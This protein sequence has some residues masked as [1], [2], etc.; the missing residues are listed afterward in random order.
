[1]SETPQDPQPLEQTI[2]RKQYHSPEFRE[3]G[4]L[5]DRTQAGQGGGPP[6]SGG[7]ITLGVA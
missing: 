2:D 7:Y 6:N 1:M 3:Y 5:Q 4:T